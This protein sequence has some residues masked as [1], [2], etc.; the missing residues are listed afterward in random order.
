MELAE[1]VKMRREQLG[2][3]QEELALRMGY[4]SR[5]SINKI[6]TGRPVT[7]KIIV[8]LAEA[9]GVSIPYLMGWDEKPAEEL[10]GMGALAGAVLSDPA[11]MEMVQDYLSLSMADQATV[12]ALVASLAAKTKKD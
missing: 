8:R 11:T 2:L 1:K 9:L 4:K 10:Q 6:E 3:S 5:S 12:R 7:Q